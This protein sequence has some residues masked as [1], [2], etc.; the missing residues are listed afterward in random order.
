MM[1]K[2]LHREIQTIIPIFE[3]TAISVSNQPANDDIQVVSSDAGDTQ[4][5]TLFGID[6]NDVFQYD[7][8]T[9]DGTDAVDSVLSPKWKTLYGVF[10]GDR[11]GNISARAT[12]TI[13][14]REKSGAQAIATI[15]AGKLSTGCLFFYA[16][17]QDIVLEN[18]SGNTWFNTKGIAS[19]TGASG[20]LT[21][22]MSID[23][24]VP[25]AEEYISLISDGSGSTAQIYVLKI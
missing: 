11:Y 16:P 22:R 21:G 13:T 8:V 9:L 2:I 14:I 20:Q 17:G 25:S 19:T 4:E 18:I 12:G 23:L 15:A 7:T 6:N 1:E 5:I 24:L 3:L 10:L